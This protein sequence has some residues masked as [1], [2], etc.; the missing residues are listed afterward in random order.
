MCVDGSMVYRKPNEANIIEMS[1]QFKCYQDLCKQGAQY[2]SET[3]RRCYWCDDASSECWTQNMPSQCNDYCEDLRQ[4]LMNESYRRG[5]T[6]GLSANKGPEYPFIISTSAVVL[7][8]LLCGFLVLRIWKLMKRIKTSR[9][10]HRSFSVHDQETPETTPL[11]QPGDEVIDMDI[12]E[13]TDDGSSTNTPGRHA[14][15][16]SGLD[17]RDS[18]HSSITPCPCNRDGNAPEVCIRGTGLK[19]LPP[20]NDDGSLKTAIL[21]G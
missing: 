17:N 9:A 20:R 6:D 7:L 1:T 15:V 19:Q 13:P 4:Q 11:T 10:E 12:T 21:C 14:S 18:M 8:V 2:C 16:D 3:R 5:Y